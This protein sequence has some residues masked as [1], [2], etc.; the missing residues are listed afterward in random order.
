MAKG[1]DSNLYPKESKDNNNYENESNGNI[2]WDSVVPIPKLQD[3]IPAEEEDE[4]LDYNISTLEIPD[5]LIGKPK[6][7]QDIFLVP[8]INDDDDTVKASLTKINK[9]SNDKIQF[10]GNPCA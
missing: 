7:A 9:D 4:F 2:E 6:I 10:Y 1:I 5:Y 8:V 3:T